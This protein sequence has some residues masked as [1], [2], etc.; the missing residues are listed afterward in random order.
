MRQPVSKSVSITP[1]TNPLTSRTLAY[2]AKPW[3]PAWAYKLCKRFMDLTI[4]VAVL[5]LVFPVLAI[6]AILI[7]LD[8]PDGPVLF[9]QE[10]TGRGGR[11]FRMYKFR[12]MRPD[13]EEL[14]KT[15][16]PVNANGELARP[17]KL[18]NDPRVTRVGGFL[19][20]TSLDEL[21]QVIN[22][23]KGEMSWVGP[24][25]TSFGLKSYSLW[26]TE[27]LDVLPGLTGLWQIYGRGST[28]FADWVRWDIRY[29]EQRC[30]W[31]DV[32]I[33]IRTA[34]AV[35]NRKGAH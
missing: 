11:R 26:Q 22:I 12:T 2:S 18:E 19:R 29:L 35:L 20:R 8:S 14:K 3:L 24:R 32:Q 30:L 34:G 9:V 23:L 4:A 10:R 6:C 5:P 31:L 1:H 28:D 7:K 17:V 16:F 33:L 21:P 13:A 27:R 25:P 15:L